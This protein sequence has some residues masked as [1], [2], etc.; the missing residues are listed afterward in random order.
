MTFAA[1]LCELNGSNA[2]EVE[3]LQAYRDVHKLLANYDAP[4][5]KLDETLIR[6]PVTCIK[7]RPTSE[8]PFFVGHKIDG[9]LGLVIR[10][11]DC[12]KEKWK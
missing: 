1:E 4:C 8:D 5:Y 11:R 9:V 10:L 3:G 2:D 7:E 6:K 12:V